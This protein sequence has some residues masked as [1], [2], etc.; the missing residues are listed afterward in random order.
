MRIHPTINIS[1]LKVYHDGSA[2]FP[3]RPFPLTRPEPV[4]VNDDGTP[5]WEV[6]RIPDHRRYGR[7]KIL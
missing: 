5:E 4:V 2:S 3:T 6:E 7:R 1:Q